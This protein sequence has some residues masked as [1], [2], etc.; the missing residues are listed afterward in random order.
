M[1]ERC[2]GLLPGQGAFQAEALHGLRAERAVREVFAAVD[3]IASAR[4]GGTVSEQVFADRPPAADRLLHENP[5]LLQ[6]AVYATSVAAHALLVDRGVR[7][8]ALA[9]HSLGEISALT[10]AG[11]FTVAQGAEIVA[12]RSAVLR[13][14]APREHVM[15][16]LGAGR[17]TVDRVLALVDPS[18]VV[19]VENGPAQV[20]VSGPA[21][22]VRVAVAVAQAAGI[23]AKELLS[24]H[25]FHHPSLAGAQ[26][27]FAA[28]MA[29]RERSAAQVPVYSP[30]LRRYYRDA[31]DI[32][33]LLA[34]HLVQPVWFG[35]T[36]EVLDR[37]PGSIFVELGAG[38]ALTTAVLSVRPVATVLRPL[39]S[40]SRT[41]DFLGLQ[42]APRPVE[43]GAE[44]AP[45]V[46]RKPLSRGRDDLLTEIRTFYAKEL[47]YPEDVF[48]EDVELEADLG[49]DSLKKSEMFVKLDRHYR[50]GV[51][52]NDPT[53][54]QVRTF[55][56][57]VDFVLTRLPAGAAR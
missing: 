29:G 42:D 38:K 11:V 51:A 4:A 5:D 46:A 8:A 24:P 3:E 53:A 57:L 40:L 10:C 50:M 33:A 6:L 14:A 2:I 22:A 49:V 31:D 19:A 45:V 23:G 48:E 12:E 52:E 54:A 55:G 27:E 41:L 7:F 37:Q 47:E 56:Q 16:A 43:R 44:P 35:E 26:V 17:G 13:A 9:G 28:R 21:E 36:V 34:L 18:V 30:I 15:A 25:G 20:V 1:N 39:S 32:G